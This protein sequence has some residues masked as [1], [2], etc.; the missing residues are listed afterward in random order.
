MISLQDLERAYVKLYKKLREYI[1][2]VPTVK[3]LANLEI[4]VYNRFPDINE[5][6]QCTDKLRS[7]IQDVINRER[8]QP[9]IYSDVYTLDDAFSDFGNLIH[10]EEANEVYAPLGKVMEVS[11]SEDQEIKSTS[12]RIRDNESSSESGSGNRVI[13]ISGEIHRRD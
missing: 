12:S 8:S 4:A 13:N 11:Y 6:R 3:D 1:W 7:D 5:V 10:S 9:K 2:D